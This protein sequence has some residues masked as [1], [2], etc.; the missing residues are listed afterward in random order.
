MNSNIKIRPYQESDAQALAE[1]FYH[2]VRKVNRKDYNEEQVKAIAPKMKGQAS[3][4]AIKWKKSPPWVAHID[5]II[6]GFIEFYDN[7]E[8]DCF[9]CHHDYIGKGVGNALMAHIKALAVEK[10]ISR[11]WANVSITA[12]P[13]FERQGFKVVKQQTVTRLGVD[14][15]NYVMEANI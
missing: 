13:F 1:I 15:I 10:R 14:L 5:K 4:W 9:Y 11:I 2:T 12:K 3:S 8:I 6:V 7:G